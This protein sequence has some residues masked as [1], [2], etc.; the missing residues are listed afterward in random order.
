MTFLKPCRPRRTFRVVVVMSSEQDLNAWGLPTRE[1]VGRQ[2]A[3]P[4][5]S[6]FQASE[7][8]VEELS[9]PWWVRLG[10]WLLGASWHLDHCPHCVRVQGGHRP[11]AWAVGMLEG[12]A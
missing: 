3:Q 12:L 7:I 2:L 8:R 1:W 5:A 9:P 11:C 4:M 10:T 6:I